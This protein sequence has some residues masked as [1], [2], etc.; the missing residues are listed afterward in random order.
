MAENT[1]KANKNSHYLTGR[2]I[3]QPHF[4]FSEYIFDLV[5]KKLRHN[6]ILGD[7]Y[8]I[9]LMKHKGITCKQVCNAYSFRL[10]TNGGS[11]YSWKM[12]SAT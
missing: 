12:R 5:F 7:T 3:R 8:K 4:I 10:S 9:N 2:E 11:G 6:I 1:N